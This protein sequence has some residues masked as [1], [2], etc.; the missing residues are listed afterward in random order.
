M[1]E[2]LIPGAAPREEG[3]AGTP[4][5]MFCLLL[6]HL[7]EAGEGT[8]QSPA[9]RGAETVGMGSLPSL[10]EGHLGHTALPLGSGTGCTSVP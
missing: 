5:R 8:E 3:D 6:P 10:L 9:P 1:V 7:L 4:E 2:F